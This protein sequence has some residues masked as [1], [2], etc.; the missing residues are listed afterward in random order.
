[1][2]SY[3]RGT[4]EYA[5][6][7]LIIRRIIALSWRSSLIVPLLADQKIDDEI[8]DYEIVRTRWVQWRLSLATLS[9][10]IFQFISSTLF[11]D[12][13]LDYRI[14][15]KTE[16]IK[17]L[18]KHIGTSPCLLKRV[19]RLCLYDRSHTIS[20]PLPLQTL[21]IFANVTCL[22]TRFPCTVET[23]THLPMLTKLSVEYMDE[24]TDN[25]FGFRDL[26]G[27]V[28]L[29]QLSI[30]RLEATV[31]NTFTQYLQ[32]ETTL[33]K[34]RI[35]YIES[36]A[37]KHLD[38]IIMNKPL[39]TKLQMPRIPKQLPSTI[40]SLSVSGGQLDIV[41]A[42]STLPKSVR[43]LR[44]FQFMID[45]NIFST[46]PQTI[47]TIRI[48]SMNADDK[49]KTAV[50]SLASMPTIKTIIV[51]LL[52]SRDIEEMPLP[53]WSSSV[54]RSYKDSESIPTISI[55]YRAP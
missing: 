30:Y 15:N 21:G 51:D 38:P 4:V 12:V 47:S 1:M 55:V 39:I 23:L 52:C 7:V 42:L 31:L 36:S 11:V 53:L 28:H 2:T 48:C 8:E 3:H 10:E 49:L 13:V 24:N 40:T 26:L 14:G 50:S 5:L 20:I 35:S 17:S 18:L 33:T 44:L 32:L 37:Q 6:P 16:M 41:T 19:E 45:L 54:C 9:K 43:H 29:C 25:A 34:L 27:L 22:G 46:L